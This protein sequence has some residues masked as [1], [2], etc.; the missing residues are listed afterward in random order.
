MPP[1][2]QSTLVGGWTSLRRSGRSRRRIPWADFLRAGGNFHEGVARSE[3]GE[4]EYWLES[5]RV[6]GARF[7]CRTVGPTHDGRLR[8]R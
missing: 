2:G 3:N 6:R 8:M 5:D 4:V 1:E 7:E